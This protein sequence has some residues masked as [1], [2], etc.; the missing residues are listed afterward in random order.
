MS[1][2]NKVVGAGEGELL[3]NADSWVLF[4]ERGG[5]PNRPEDSAPGQRTFGRYIRAHAPKIEVCM[6]PHLEQ[7]RQAPDRPRWH[8]GNVAGLREK[9]SW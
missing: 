2:C 4:R 8:T 3:K 9:G 1:V 6:N 5:P 7:V